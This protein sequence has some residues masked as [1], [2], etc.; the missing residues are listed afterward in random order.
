MK[1]KG[2][3]VFITGHTG[4]KG[5]WLTRW[6]IDAGA[7]VCGYSI[8]IPTKPSLFEALGLAGWIRHHMGDVCDFGRLKSV[9]D[10][11][12]PEIVFHLAA[13]PLVRKSYDDPLST[14]STNIMGT[15]HMM[16]CLRRNSSV[17]AAVM[18]TSDKC[19]E[20]VGQEAGYTETDR[21]GGQDPYSASKG[22]AEI[23]FSSYVRSF[24]GRGSAG[25]ASARAGN[26]IGGGDWSEDRIVADCA[27]AWSEGKSV[28]LRN[29]A[30]VRPWQHVLDCLSGYLTLACALLESPEN[31]RGQS[32]NF[33]PSEKE[34][35]TVQELCDLMREYWPEAKWHKVDAEPTKSESVLLKL[36]CEKAYRILG[37]QPVWGFQDAVKN[38]AAWYRRYYIG[39]GS[40]RG[41]VAS[42]AA[43]EKE[44]LDQLAE[45]TRRGKKLGLAWA[46]P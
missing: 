13:Q 23:I 3:R 34:N 27:R 22:A 1:F 29:P 36:N 35:F 9:F 45:F 2:K 8:D 44:T 7:E 21:L 40:M 37:W 17:R 41:P 30:S 20:N 12:Q 18:V 15:A 14:F 32:F 28:G 31:F 19:Y 25:I 42:K 5:S 43:I 46:A 16:E 26:V 33:G 24:F 11:F 39:D 4:F 38:T 10:E 6:L